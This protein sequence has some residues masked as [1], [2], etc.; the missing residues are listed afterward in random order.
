MSSGPASMADALVE[1]ALVVLIRRLG[2]DGHREMAALVDGGVG[3]IEVS[4]VH[5]DPAGLIAEWRRRHPDVLVGAG[6]VRTRDAA[7]AA[8][9]A[10]AQFLVSPGFVSAVADVAERRDALYVPGVLTPTEIDVALAAGAPLLKLFPAGAVGA[11]YLSDVLGAFPGTRFLVSGGIGA[12]NIESFRA[13][14][15]SV[16]CVGGAL[17]APAELGDRLATE[18]AALLDVLRE[19]TS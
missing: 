8:L 14:G 3:A 18:V 4:F 2:V 15:A 11:R 13:A 19:A 1:R 5:P 9:D 10:G 6:T 7:A 17:S 12:S 16:C